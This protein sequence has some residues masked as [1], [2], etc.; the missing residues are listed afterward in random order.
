MNADSVLTMLAIVFVLIAAVAIV[1][2]NELF[3]TAARWV[4][5]AVWLIA[6]ISCAFALSCGF[7]S[8]SLKTRIPVC[9]DCNQLQITKEHA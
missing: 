8:Y 6:M 9:S 7:Y 4:V 2:A 1:L 3:H 5:V